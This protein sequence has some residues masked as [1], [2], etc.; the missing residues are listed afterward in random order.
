MLAGCVY[1]FPH[2]LSEWQ[3]VAGLEIHKVLHFV[4]PEDDSA[5]RP[6]LAGLPMDEEV[7][8]ADDCKRKLVATG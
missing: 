4:Q 2:R 6:R 8:H 7:Q 3:I 5:Q 1:D